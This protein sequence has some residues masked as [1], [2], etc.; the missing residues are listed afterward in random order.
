MLFAVTFCRTRKTVDEKFA[1][2]ATQEAPITVVD[3]GTSTSRP[4]DP[5]KINEAN[6]NETT[7]GENPSYTGPNYINMNINTGTNNE[8]ASA[9]M[10]SGNNI[11]TGS[12]NTATGINT[13]NIT[14]VTNTPQI[15]K[16]VV[17]ATEETR[18][19]IPGNVHERLS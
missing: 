9:N 3:L 18:L 14:K 8:I 5:S 16:N 19:C 7:N 15:P 2:V 1:D 17:Q 13:D 10:N 12:N 11:N 6:E 4:D